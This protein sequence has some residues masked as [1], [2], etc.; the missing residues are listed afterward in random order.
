MNLYPAVN[1]S[2]TTNCFDVIVTI[3]NFDWLQ[4]KLIVYFQFVTGKCVGFITKANSGLRFGQIQGDNETVGLGL[5]G[6]DT[7]TYHCHLL[8]SV[9]TIMFQ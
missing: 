9:V 1:W 4:I 7:R 8:Q 3:S 6:F 2:T 5:S